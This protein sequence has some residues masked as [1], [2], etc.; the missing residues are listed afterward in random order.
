MSEPPYRR[1][2]AA[3]I[4][5]GTLPVVAAVQVVAAPLCPRCHFPTESSDIESGGVEVLDIAQ[6]KDGWLAQG[7]VTGKWR[8]PVCGSAYWAAARYIPIECG[9]DP[10]PNCGPGATLTPDILQISRIESGYV[11]TAALKCDKCSR[12]RRF[13]KLLKPLSRSR[14]KRVKVGPTGIEVEVSAK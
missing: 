4:P 5:G 7:R 6:I 8:C 11:F 14:L 3:I 1:V 13:R 9:E 2:E 12:P 10:C